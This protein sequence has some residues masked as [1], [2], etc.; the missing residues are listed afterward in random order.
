ME[1]PEGRSLPWKEAVLWQ[2][3]WYRWCTTE[4]PRYFAWKRKQVRLYQGQDCIACSYKVHATELLRWE[5]CKAQG[6]FNGSRPQCTLSVIQQAAERGH[7]ELEPLKVPGPG[8]YQ[9]GMMRSTS[10]SFRKRTKPTNR[11]NTIE[12]Q[13]E[14]PGPGAYEN[15]EALNSSGS[16]IVSKHAGSGTT[17]FN[18][19]HSKRFAEMSKATP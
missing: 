18:P 6:I 8:A 19:K 9:S 11:V 15:P 12:S 13:N 7:I 2:H 17:K 4:R 5:H 1:L 10:Y 3:L 16:Y 14:N